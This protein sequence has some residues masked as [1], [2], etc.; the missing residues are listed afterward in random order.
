MRG[1]FALVVVIAIVAVGFYR[2]W[3]SISWDKTEKGGQVTGTMDKDKIEADKK[4]AA[5][6]VH[7]LGDSKANAGPATKKD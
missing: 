1:L 2:G 7:R 6:E 3:F 5:E 4:R